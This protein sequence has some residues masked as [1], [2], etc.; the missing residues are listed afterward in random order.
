MMKTYQL[1]NEG[2]FGTSKKVTPMTTEEVRNELNCFSVE[3]S[4]DNPVDPQG[5]LPDMT[6]FQVGLQLSK[7]F[8][9]T[10]YD[11]I[12]NIWTWQLIGTEVM[13]G[14][15]C[16]RWEYI[17]SYG[18][19]SN[20]YT[21]W[22]QR[23][24][25]GSRHPIVVPVRYELKG[26]KSL[27]GSHY[28][29]YYLDYENFLTED[30]SEDAFTIGADVASCHGFPGPG[31]ADHVYTFNPMKEFVHGH[32]RHVDESF[33]SFRHRHSKQYDDETDHEHR[34]NIFRQ[35]MR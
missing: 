11:Y 19:K 26:Y 33:D 4:K 25:E 14:V 34:K 17:N 5:V 7:S 18:D 27:L 6:N 9:L 12:C 16:E 31:V 29:H 10:S 24:L 15:T 1:A 23:Q 35:N 8:E 13:N 3:G 30:P 28:D 22:L 21:L 2:K 32:D 20:R